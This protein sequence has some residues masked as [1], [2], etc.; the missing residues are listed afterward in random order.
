MTSLATG[1]SVGAVILAAGESRRFDGIKALAP[2]Q[3]TTLLGHAIATARSLCGDSIVVVTGAHDLTAQLRGAHSMQN[4]AWADG[5]GGSIATGLRALLDYAPTLPHALILPIDQ[6]LM[7]TA[8]LQALFTAAKT[9]GRAALTS[10]GAR[11]G[12][13]ACLP[14]SCYAAALRLSGEQGLKAALPAAALTT[15][16]NTEALLDADTKGALAILA[17][18]AQS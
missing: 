16:E 17:R 5:M 11:R 1:R 2:W 9:T 12:P 10:D 15:V 7:T 13:P 14:A 6:P 18:K 4:G 3:G 8:H